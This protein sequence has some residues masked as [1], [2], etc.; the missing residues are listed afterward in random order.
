VHPSEQPADANCNYRGR[1]W[2]GL[3]VATQPFFERGSSF[4]GGA[5]RIGSAVWGLAVKV[6]RG[7]GGLIYNPF[8]SGFCVAR[9]A[10]EIFLYFTADISGGSSYSIFVHGHYSWL[11]HS[12][13]QL[14]G[15]WEG[16]DLGRWATVFGRRPETIWLWASISAKWRTGVGKRPSR[17]RQA[18]RGTERQILE[19]AD[20]VIG[21]W[22]E[23]R[24]CRPN[25]PFA[26]L[27]VIT[28]ER[29]RGVL[30]RA[31]RQNVAPSPKS[32]ETPRVLR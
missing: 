9:D 17:K 4:T 16:S 14:G 12:K 24:S 28:V 23:R 30:R 11:Q 15:M 18:R 27:E 6:L 31:Q 20:Q 1:V 32:A 25:A 8:G 19:D 10:T 22:N 5:G 2:L 7:A 21:V 3:D 13:S 26:E 29:C